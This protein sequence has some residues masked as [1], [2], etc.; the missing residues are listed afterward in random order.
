V[1]PRN[2]TG[3]CE[4]F[5]SKFMYV[6]HSVP[7]EWRVKIG[8]ANRLNKETRGRKISI[9]TKG[10]PKS[11]EARKKMSISATGRIIWRKERSEKEEIGFV[12][13]KESTVWLVR[14]V[15]D[16][17]LVVCCAVIVYFVR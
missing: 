7:A 16:L 11:E 10:K 15:S 9:A 3:E 4:K 8:A 17:L 13:F 6:G 14:R 2:K 5:I 12:Y 1:P